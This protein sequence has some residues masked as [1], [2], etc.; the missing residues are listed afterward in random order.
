MFKNMVIEA[1]AKLYSCIL[2]TFSKLLL[3]MFFH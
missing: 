1:D 3:I 2:K